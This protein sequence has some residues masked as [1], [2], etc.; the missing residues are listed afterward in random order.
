MYEIIIYTSIESN[1]ALSI[2]RGKLDEQK[3][4]VDNIIPQSYCLK[5]NDRWVKDL[6]V[7]KNK[8]LKNMLFISSSLT[9]LP[10]QMENLIYIKPFYGN[11]EDTELY[12]VAKLLKSISKTSDIR[13]EIKRI[14]P[15]ISLYNDYIKEENKTLIDN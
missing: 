8:E 15:Y 9:S 6:R 10:N 12:N 7:F 13:N 11:K 1:L 2:I 5:V 14:N 3:I 4:Y